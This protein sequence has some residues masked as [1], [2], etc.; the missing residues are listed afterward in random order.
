MKKIGEQKAYKGIAYSVI[1]NLLFFIPF[2]SL[3]TLHYEMPDNLTYAQFIAEGSYTFDYMGFFVCAFYGL[4]QKIIYPLNAFVFM[5]LFF[6]LASF[7]SITFVFLRKFNWIFATLATLLINAFYAVSHYGNISFTRDPALFCVAGFLLIIHF[8][9]KK[10]WILPVALGA[11]LIILGSMYRFLVFEVSVLFA[12]AFVLGKSLNEFFA[13]DKK[14]RNIKKLFSVIFEKRRFIVAVLLVVVCFAF[15]FVSIAINTSTPD[16]E[17]YREYTYA[18]QAVYD[19]PIPE[20]SE[21]KEEYDKINFDENDIKMLREWYIDDEGAFTLENLKEL[22]NIQEKY[23]S[24]NKDYVDIIKNMVVTEIANVR[25]I[26]DKGVAL[27]GFCIVLLPFFVIMKKRSYFIPL[28]FVGSV[29]AVYLYLWNTGRIPPYRGVYMLWISAEVYLLY[30]FSLS[31]TK[32]FFANIYNKKKT[33]VT[34]LI[35]AFVVLSSAMGFYLSITANYTLPTYNEVDS[36]AELKEY[37]ESNKDKKFELSRACGL[38]T[39]ENNVFYIPER[40]SIDEQSFSFINTYYRYENYTNHM[41][42]FGTDNMYSNLLNDDVYFV[43]SVNND[44]VQMMNDYLNKY[45][46]N[47]NSI[48][49][50]AVDKVGNYMIYKFA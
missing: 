24:E 16:L 18:R 28:L 8:V 35:S 15:Q 7:V 44:H 41:K 33:I 47:D 38:D 42:E 26:G 9:D 14:E 34:L 50:S 48:K 29:F 30:S 43:C 37:F 17:Y 19:Y 5:H 22:K 23:Y 1:L 3:Y 6:C 20:Y 49:Y 11:F 10:R 27:F 4:I 13:T 45:Y 12:V 2:L 31:D 21:C 39:A 40:T 25:G 32:Q 36:T 46:S